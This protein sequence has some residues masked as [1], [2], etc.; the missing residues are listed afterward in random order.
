MPGRVF[1]RAVRIILAAAVTLNVLL[2][3][4]SSTETERK[5][6]IQQLVLDKP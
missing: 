5:A 1:R 6:I 3:K 2:W 4:E